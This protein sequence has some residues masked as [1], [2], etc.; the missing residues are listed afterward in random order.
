MMSTMNLPAELHEQLTTFILAHTAD[1]AASIAGLRAMPGHAGFSYGFSAT[2]RSEGGNETTDPFVLRLPPPGVRYEGTA[3][4]LRQVRVLDV[5]QGSGVPV[6]PV[7]WSGDDPRWFG[8]PYFI[9]PRLPGDTLRAGEGPWESSPDETLRAMAGQVI[10]AMVALHAVSWEQAL[11]EWGPPLDPATDVVRWDRIWERSADPELVIQAPEVR[12]RLLERLP[13]SPLNGI[14]HGDFQWTNVL[15]DGDRLVAVLDWELA[16]I[17]PVLNDLGWIMAFSD[18]ANWTNEVYTTA[19]L[20][21][22][23]ALRS[24]YATAVGHDPGD[25]AWYRALAGYKFAII[26]GFNLMLHRRGRRDDPFWEVLA[27]SIPRLLG[28]ALDVLNGNV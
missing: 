6:A 19:P 12:R 5:L 11:P 17:G 18:P 26:S 16:G 15:F 1:A 20:P 9:V 10:E 21:S 22:P 3:D 8:R 13:L 23:D 24:L 14:V 25:V 7:R 4:V 28:R 27:P 2:Y